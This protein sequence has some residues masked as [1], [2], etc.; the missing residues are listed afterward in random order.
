MGAVGYEIQRKIFLGYS[1]ANTDFAIRLA[2]ELKSVGFHIWV[3]V[4]DIPVG[5][6]WDVEVEKALKECEI[7]MIVLTPSAIAS[8]N[9]KDEI[10]YAID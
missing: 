7:F 10:G 5:S 2:K 6:R 9:V 8:E 1:R 4:L 3:D